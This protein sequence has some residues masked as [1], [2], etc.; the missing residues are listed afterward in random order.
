VD[1]SICNILVKKIVSF[2]CD[3]IILKTFSRDNFFPS[4]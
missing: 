1:L 3:I 4:H 2:Q